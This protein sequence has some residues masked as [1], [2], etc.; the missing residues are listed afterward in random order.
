M[1]KIKTAFDLKVVRLPLSALVETCPRKNY[2]T[3]GSYL[4]ILASYKEYGFFLQPISIYP[5]KIAGKYKILEGHLRYYVVRDCGDN[6]IDCIIEDD[7][8]RFTQNDKINAINPIQRVKMLKNAIKGGASI[9][10]ISRALSWD[11]SKILAEIDASDGIDDEARKILKD[12]PISVASLRML[13]KVKPLR[14]VQIAE[15]IVAANIFDIHYVSGLVLSTSA[16][17]LKDEY[18]KK[19]VPKKLITQDA[20][21]SISAEQKNVHSKL[22]EIREKYNSNMCELVTIVNFLKK[23][24][25]N[26]VLSNYLKRTFEDI[27]CGFT[28]ISQS[29]IFKIDNDE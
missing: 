22:K 7:D 4:S 27:Y 12:A 5:S 28:Q 11:K 24:L 2:Q 19:I 9:D 29:N 15:S 23:I 17:L 21:A 3:M 25:D 18:K 26:S 8:E 14:Q 13:R 6:E 10:K 16:D 20:Y 1:N